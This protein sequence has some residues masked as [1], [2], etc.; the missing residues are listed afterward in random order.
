MTGRPQPDR[1]PFTGPTGNFSPVPQPLHASCPIPDADNSGE[2]IMQKIVLAVAAVAGLALPSPAH[3]ASTGPAG[4]SRAK[5]DLTLSYMA[6][7]GYAAA[8]RLTC[9][10]G[11]VHPQAK[12]ACGTLKKVGGDPG[13]ITPAKTMCT[14][15][16]A[17]ITASVTGTWQGRSVKWSK[18]FGNQ[19]VMR[20]AT[21]V[22]FSF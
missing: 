1:P 9:S 14:M 18:Q 7:A 13:R 2:K 5:T 15:V 11:D 10:A 22:L 20:R 12:K 6:D 16:F 17:P 8:V 19:C 4:Q 21:G 3:A